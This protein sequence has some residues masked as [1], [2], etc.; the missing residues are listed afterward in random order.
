M[1][2]PQKADSWIQGQKG[3]TIFLFLLPLFNVRPLHPLPIY[4]A[5]ILTGF[6]PLGSPTHTHYL[7]KRRYLIMSLLCL[8]T[9]YCLPVGNAQTF[10]SDTGWSLLASWATPHEATQ[11]PSIFGDSW[12]HFP[13][14]F[15]CAF[16]Y[17]IPSAWNVMPSLPPWPW[18]ELFTFKTV[19]HFLETA[20]LSGQS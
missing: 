3:S 13:P 5:C 16:A 14:L 8:A 12:N 2:T 1:E 15:F 18:G 17:A 6:L 19:S 9:S 20:C 10:Q 7:F 11:A 4:F